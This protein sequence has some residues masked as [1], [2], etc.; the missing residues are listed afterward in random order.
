MWRCSTTHS[1]GSSPA[2]EPDRQLQRLEVLVTKVGA[3]RRLIVAQGQERLL[4]VA[5]VGS[6]DDCR[7]HGHAWIDTARRSLSF[8]AQLWLAFAEQAGVGEPLRSAMAEAL[9]TGTARL[10]PGT[11]QFLANLPAAKPGAMTVA[12][13]E[14][15]ALIDAKALSRAL[16]GEASSPTL[17][18]ALAIG[19]SP[20]EAVAW[21]ELAFI[22]GEGGDVLPTRAAYLGLMMTMGGGARVAA[23]LPDYQATPQ[24]DPPSLADLDMLE[25]RR[26]IETTARRIAAIS[27]IPFTV[28]RASCC[29]RRQAGLLRSRCWRCTSAH[30]FPVRQRPRALQH[31]IW[32]GSWSALA[33]AKEC[34]RRCSIAR[35]QASSRFTPQRATCASIFSNATSNILKRRQS[36]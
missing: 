17:L 28:R 34:P 15:A 22:G 2:T 35:R 9:R 27:R 30:C 7:I 18:R 8:L 26:M 23:P 16:G 31:A 29:F 10:E 24:L 6:L 21:E 3:V 32:I 5:G 25:R 19:S 20:R 33:H 36:T 4:E 13:A 14:R 12:E 11:L 1:A